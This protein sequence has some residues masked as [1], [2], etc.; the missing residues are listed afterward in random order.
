MMKEEIEK[1]LIGQLAIL[2]GVGEDCIMGDSLLQS[3]GMDSMR[4]VE[5]FIFIE[6]EFGV[7][8]MSTDMQRSDLETPQALAVSIARNL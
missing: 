2:L 4:F 3:L 5:L 6:K 1:K 8:L 7:E